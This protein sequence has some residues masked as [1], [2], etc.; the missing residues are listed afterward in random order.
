[1]SSGGEPFDAG[2]LTFGIRVQGVTHGIFTIAGVSPEGRR[3]RR[4]YTGWTP[5]DGRGHILARIVRSSTQQAGWSAVRQSLLIRRSPRHGTPEGWHSEEGFR[6]S[7]MMSSP[8]RRGDRP[9]A[10]TPGTTYPTPG[11]GLKIDA[12]GG[13]APPR[14]D[15]FETDPDRRQ[16]SYAVPDFPGPLPNEPDCLR[17]IA[18]CGASWPRCG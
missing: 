1:M 7:G 14:H 9:V 13:S 5:T 8:T 3:M 11:Q 6:V 17:Y 4:P 10:P 12:H 18:E 16:G 2:R 15:D